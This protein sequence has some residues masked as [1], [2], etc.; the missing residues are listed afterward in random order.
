MALSF[1]SREKQEDDQTAAVP[2]QQRMIGRYGSGFQ[3]IAGEAA[4]F[5][6]LPSEP[7]ETWAARHKRGNRDSYGGPS[8]WVETGAEKRR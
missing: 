4:Y 3:E 2:P 1:Q 6:T 8:G 7:R 5:S